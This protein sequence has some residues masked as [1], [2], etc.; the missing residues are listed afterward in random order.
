MR[1]FVEEPAPPAPAPDRREPIFFAWTRSFWLG[2]LPILAIFADVVAQVLGM[3]GD[4]TLGPPVAG[5][6]ASLLGYDAAE[7]EAVM[8]KL[9]PVFAIVIAQQRA[10]ASRPYTIDPRALK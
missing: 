3:L 6:I 7:V 8:L 4:A 10:G 1:D 5:L 2:L 9:T